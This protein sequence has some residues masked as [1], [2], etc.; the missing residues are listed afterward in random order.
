MD[1][2][3]PFLAPFLGFVFQQFRARKGFPE[4]GYWLMAFGA[5]VFCLWLWND[6]VNLVTK[7]FWRMHLGMLVTWV[8][9]VAG[10][11]M[12]ASGAAKAGAPDVLAPLTNSK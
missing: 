10:G 9:S 3:A 1:Q 2:V 7:E 5:G 6:S 11:T 12:A 4:W 8:M